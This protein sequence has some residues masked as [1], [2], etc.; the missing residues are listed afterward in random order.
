MFVKRV[1]YLVG[2]GR[3]IMPLWLD[4]SPPFACRMISVTT[5][6]SSSFRS[7]RDLWLHMAEHKDATMEVEQPG[8]PASMAL[9]G[10][11]IT[12]ASLN[13]TG[14]LMHSVILWLIRVNNGSNRVIISSIRMMKSS[15]SKRSS[16]TSTDKQT[17]N[18]LVPRN[19][20]IRISG[21]LRTCESPCRSPWCSELRYWKM[22]RTFPV[23]T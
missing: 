13:G 21:Q 12:S 6:R 23:R 17:P 10:I 7:L 16:F 8:N 14:V 18:T 11:I 20:P 19:W 9:G 5:S 4:E 2:K 22:R 1:A 15:A 3:F